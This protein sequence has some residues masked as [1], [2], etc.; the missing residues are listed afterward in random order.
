M[1][2]TYSIPLYITKYNFLWVLKYSW[3][4]GQSYWYQ[5]S[6]SLMECKTWKFRIQFWWSSIASESFLR[7]SYSLLRMEL[8]RNYVPDFV[9]N[10]EKI[11]GRGCFWRQLY[12]LI[13]AGFPHSI[14]FG[15]LFCLGGLYKST[16]DTQV[17][18]LLNMLPS[19]S[20][21]EQKYIDQNQ[22]FCWN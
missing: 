2:F 5:T 18:G 4:V 21:T 13:K 3:L 8:W 16:S 10:A 20:Q 6:S 19:P 17:L 1:V 14:Q 15:C 9:F 12:T 7:A 22:K 11:L